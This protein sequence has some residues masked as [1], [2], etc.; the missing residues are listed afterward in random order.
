[1]I[2]LLVLIFIAMV[3]S[4]YKLSAGALIPYIYL[5]GSLILIF[6]QLSALLLARG[7]GIKFIAVLGSLILT[8]IILALSYFYPELL[9]SFFPLLFAGALFG[10]SLGLQ[11]FQEK[12]HH[13]MNKWLDKINWTVPLILFP[14]LIFQ[15]KS[16]HI[17]SICGL[18]VIIQIIANLALMSLKS[19]RKS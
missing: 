13:S 11:S 10:I 18:L 17:W 6:I 2:T 3:Y 12:K 5:S 15:L 9:K 4:I 1:M 19:F 16:E 7:S 14:L 8:S